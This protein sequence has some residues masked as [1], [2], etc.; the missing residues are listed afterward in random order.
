MKEDNRI[1]TGKLIGYCGVRFR[2]NYNPQ[3]DLKCATIA[4]VR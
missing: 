4:I 2:Q 3:S 1:E